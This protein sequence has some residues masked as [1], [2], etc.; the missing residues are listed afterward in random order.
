MSDI[1]LLIDFGSTFTK[2]VAIDL[3]AEE[4]VASTRVPSTVESDITTGLKH[5]LH[6]IEGTTGIGDLE[7]REALA[8]SSAAGGLRMVCAG[9]VPEL[10]AT[11]A[12][13]REGR[14]ARVFRGRSSPN[15][16]ARLTQASVPCHGGG[17]EPPLKLWR[18]P[19]R[20]NHTK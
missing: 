20:V 2:V 14:R 15:E 10:T 3:T 8:C 6:N 13:V 18:D 12:V 5:A 11:E 4:V 16:E 1:R 19:R 17:S 9:F 7:E